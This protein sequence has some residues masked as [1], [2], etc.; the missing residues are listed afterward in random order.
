MK[1]KVTILLFSISIIT[2]AAEPR[3]SRAAYIEEH[4][5]EA[6]SDMKRTGVPASITL[7]QACLESMDGNSPLAVKANNHFGIKCSD[8]KGA[9][10]IQDDDTKDECFRKYGSTL[11]S[12]DDHSNFLRTRPRYAFL[13]QLDPTDYKGWARG[14]KKAG[15]ATDPRYADRL[16]K[17]IEENKLYLLDMEQPLPMLASADDGKGR[18]VIS[19]SPKPVIVPPGDVV[20]ETDPLNSRPVLESNGIPCIIARQGDTFRSLSKELGLGYWQLPKYNEMDEYTQLSPG[21]IVYI[22][23]KNK[24]AT[25]DVHTVKEGESVLSIAHNYGVKVKY[26]YNYNNLKDGQ[27]IEPGMQIYLKKNRQVRS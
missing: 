13:F 2:Q 14:L 22:K 19:E 5:D 21:Q 20:L 12:Y 27:T 3:R 23:P 4:K 17:I 26:I 24:E 11:E 10:Y 16:I 8:W 25:R 6:I 18:Q 15:Y 9:Y 1:I 7:A